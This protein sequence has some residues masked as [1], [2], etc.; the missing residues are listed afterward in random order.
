MCGIAGISPFE[1]DKDIVVIKKMV[2]SICHRGPD[3][4]NIF[5][6]RLGIFGFLR[7]KIIDLSEKS[8]QPFISENQKIQ[9]FYNGEIYNYKE[10]KEAYFPNLKF[11]SDGD[12]EIILYLYEKFGMNFLDKIKGMF[13]I[14][15]IDNQIGKI[16][17][18]RDRFGIKP[19]YY[20]LIKKKIYFCSELKGLMQSESKNEINKSEAYKFFKQGLV[21]STNETWIKN[22]YQV[23]ASHYLEFNDGKFLEKK[24]YK[25]E[26]SIDEDLDNQKK[27]FKFYI[28]EFKERLLKSFEEHNRFDVTAGVHLS[29]GVDSA[30][31]SAL[32]NYNNK[33]YRS[34]TF[35]FND[36]KYSEIDYAKKIAESAKLSNY[37][38]ILDEKRIPEYLLNVL[39]R[40][41]EPFSSLRILSQH[42]LYDKFKKDCRVIFDGS[43]GDEI[44][45]GYS[46]YL[47]PWY[48]DNIKIFN[49]EK[50]KKRFYRNVNFIKNET[51]SVSQFIKGSF[52]QFKRPGSSTIDGSMYQNNSIYSKEFLKFND[53]LI[54]KKPFK[55]HLRNAQYADLFHLKLPRSLKYADRSSMYNSIETRVPFLDHKVVEWSLQIPSKFKLLQNQQRIIMK[56]PFKNYVNNEVL[57]LNK[58]TIADPQS[59]WLKTHLKPMFYD[60]VNSKDFNNH[61]FFDKKNIINYFEKFLKSS[62]H[63]NSFL[64]FQILISELWSQNILL[65][66][67]I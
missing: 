28:E 6:N 12:G 53:E 43:G 56:Y 38:T 23:K 58:R 51:L 54:I 9:I 22:I 13:S 26:D 61:G 50:I 67:K 48:L 5:K 8:N 14:A 64:I 27:S 4:E 15:I 34:Y 2:N 59:S 3:Q 21:N 19:L 16:F 57:Y 1:N 29:G 30:I 49:K 65:K 36:K 66:N 32:M 17:L 40:E 25:I 45:A 44:G 37:S 35:D 41:F 7:L 55:S 24:Y 31:L 20:R 18:I 42:N 10:L 63:F 47:A 11:K 33:D 52:A 39:D 46:Y 62:E 60:T